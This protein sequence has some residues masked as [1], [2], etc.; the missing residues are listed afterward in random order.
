MLEATNHMV[1]PPF[2]NESYIDPSDPG[3]REKMRSA[4]E[5]LRSESKEYDLMV[6]GEPISTEKR[7]LSRNP[8][9]PEEIVGR[10]SS[11]NM[12]IVDKALN[13]A[14]K[15]FE[16]WSMLPAYERVKPF[17]RAA[18]I[19]RQK[20]FELDATM[21]L[22]VGKSWIEADADLAEAIDF[23]E[24]YS[25]EALRYDEPQP[26]V[27][28][29]GEYNLLRYIPLGVGAV[30]PP[31]NFPCAI[32]VGMTTAAAVS[33][34]CVLLKPASDSPVI[35]AKF[36]Q[37][38]K[39]AGLPDGVVNFIPGSGGEIGDYIVENPAIRFVSFTGS[40]EVGLRIN[41]LAAR[42][43]VGQK[44]IKRVVLEMGGKD[45]VVVDESADLEAA[46]DGAVASAFGFQG[47]KCS[48]GSRIIV[49]EDVYEKMV[50][51][52]K[53]KTEKLTVGDTTDPDNYMGPV[54][55]ENAMKRILGY[56]DKGESEGR[57]LT[58]GKRLDGTGFFIEPTVFFDVPP[59]AV[60]A[61]EEIFGP[62]TAVIKAKDFEDAMKIAN[63]TEYGLTGSLYSKN[64]HRIER[65]KAI[66]HVGNLYFNRKCTGALVG[67]QPFGGFNM[68]GTD[69]KAGG[70]D[71]LLLFL[72]GK[73]ISEKII[74]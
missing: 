25:R 70:R 28:V 58:G 3:V 21:I 53:E 11:A 16:S 45:C 61:Q 59:D 18:E 15:A 1:I 74:P 67:V 36:V 39:E 73:S 44:W 42:H 71:Y 43:H 19:M 12:G 17:L 35:A 29:P 38:L 30:I 5:A 37:I 63:G 2:R 7:I 56:I 34:N 68:S 14:Y 40:K 26:V 49:V 62:V 57:L 54:I 4:I 20:R 46:S 52:I 31:W 22:E 60:I 10:V 69:S 8:A 64:R 9:N 65:A 66:F 41:E 6:G 13:C 27:Q 33:G 47:Q 24:F 23:L 51:M 72:Q 55:N 48:A 32:M 50:A